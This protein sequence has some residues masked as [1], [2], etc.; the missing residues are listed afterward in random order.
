MLK[1]NEGDRDTSET[2]EE[3]KEPKTSRRLIYVDA[4]G[5]EDNT[6]FKIS[7]YDK[8][9]NATHVLQLKDIKHNTEA[10]QY[11]ILYAILYVK[12][13]NYKRC[14]I[15]CDNQSA[16]SSKLIEFLSKDYNIGVSWIPREANI[17]ADKISK[18]EP[19]LKEK[20][21]N[22]L[23]LFVELVKK[24]CHNVKETQDKFN[25]KIES[26]SDQIEKLN[27]TIEK[28]KNKITN[29]KMQINNLQ[30]KK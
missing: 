25:N 7:L 23:Q 29:Q 9:K 13:H 6:L 28:Q 10:E 4:S 24:Q 27:G 8:E 1:M 15:L 21:W 3:I 18:L 11:A 22:L 26:L 17:I 20:E 16:V 5:M 14:H 19:T 12:K 30:N 2:N